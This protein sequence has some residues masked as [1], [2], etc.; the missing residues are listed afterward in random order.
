MKHQ[1]FCIYLILAFFYNKSTNRKIVFLLFSLFFV[2]TRAKSQYFANKYISKLEINENDSLVFLGDSLIVDTLKMFD[3]SSLRFTKS[4]YIVFKN[5]FF[6]EGVKILSNGTS[7][8]SGHEISKINGL[9]NQNGRYKSDGSD[10]L[11]GE[12][13]FIILS[14]SSLGSLV[15]DTSGGNGGDGENGFSQKDKIKENRLDTTGKFKIK[16][17]GKIGGKGGEGKNAGN[18]NLYYTYNKVIPRFNREGKNSI[19]L[20]AKGGVCGKN[21]ITDPYFYSDSNGCFSGNDGNV[22]FKRLKE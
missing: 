4:T 18:I 10:G 15:I 12:N 8:L 22:F 9:D 17:T 3:N 5:A 13:L 16:S 21:G 20:T 2:N 7:G 1:L 11:H 19:I 14:F 6:G